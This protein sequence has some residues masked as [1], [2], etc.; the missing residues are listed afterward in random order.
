M[1]DF[2]NMPVGYMLNCSVAGKMPA[3]ATSA[4][5]RHFHTS[6]QQVETSVI[7]LARN[8]YRGWSFCPLFNPPKRRENFV[9]ASTI[10]FDFDHHGLE[11]LRD[12]GLVYMNAAFVYATPSSTP[13]NPRCRAVFV[14]DEPV[15][16]SAEFT[17]I[18]HALAWW[19]GGE[20]FTTD[21]ACKDPLRLYYGSPR[22]AMWH[23]WSVLPRETCRVYVEQWRDAVPSANEYAPPRVVNAAPAESLPARFLTTAAERLLENVRTAPDGEKHYTLRKIAYVFGGYVAGG[24]YSRSD[25]VQ[26]LQD[27]IRPRAADMQ[28]ASRTI[29]D[30]LLAGMAEPLAFEARP[31]APRA[32]AVGHADISAALAVA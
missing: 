7:D 32:R 23:N 5:W 6:W 21:P 13:D 24:Y 27:A 10:A 14:F 8:I 11:S 30:C 12:T 4:Q 20:G 26:W 1:D 17:D 29:E 9:S 31:T 25:A 16:D 28:L 19:F 22:G 15:T 3:N 2:R 18:Y